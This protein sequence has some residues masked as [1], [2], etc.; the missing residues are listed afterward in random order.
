MRYIWSVIC[1][2]ALIDTQTNTL[3][4]QDVAEQLDISVNKEE[5]EKSDKP[6]KI[7]AEF[8]IIQMWKDDEKE[9][10]REFEGRIEL[11]DPSGKVL[12]T[13][14]MPLRFKK[15]TNRLRNR[16]HVQGMVVTQEGEYQYVSKIKEGGKFKKVGSVPLDIVVSYNLGK[17]KK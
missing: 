14:D 2:K 3:S 4:I 15:G 13:N 6:L 17:N 1:Q 5:L 11:H 16:I 7:S 10:D 8:D 9:K 12:G